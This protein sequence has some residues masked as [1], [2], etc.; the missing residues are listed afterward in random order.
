MRGDT[1]L[2][3]HEAVGSATRKNEPPLGPVLALADAGVWPAPAL[4]PFAEL[5]RSCLESNRT[6]RPQSVREV[7]Q[8]LREIRGGLTEYALVQCCI[9]LDDVDRAVC[10]SCKPG[11]ERG[12]AQA[13]GSAAPAPAQ[14]QQQQQHHLC[15]GCLSRHVETC[16]QPAKLEAHGGLIPCPEATCPARP[17]K[18]EDLAGH[19]DKASFAAYAGALRYH[20]ADV[21]R[22]KREAKEAMDRAAAAALAAEARADRV[23]L[24]RLTVIERDLTLH[25]PRCSGAFL[26]YSGCNALTCAR[27]AAGFCALCLADCGRDA[28]AHYY[29][30]HGQHI[31]DAP[32]F[33]AVHR[34]LRRAAVAGAIQALA[35]Q[36][37]AGALQAE[38]LQALRKDLE[39]L[40]IDFEGVR[41]DAGL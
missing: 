29:A 37:E 32:R 24:L 22:L 40:G 3:L 28:H 34:G 1:A 26:D 5:I 4:K 20:F 25:C 6:A 9:C 30:T 17:H 31:F 35:G 13:G 18:I 36:R 11:G 27:C 8:R 38:L 10:L 7:A 16:S 33:A 41:R 2:T 12:G 21:A 15:L 39:D 14:Q 23:R 19:L